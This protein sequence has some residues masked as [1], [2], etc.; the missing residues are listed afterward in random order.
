MSEMGKENIGKIYKNRHKYLEGTKEPIYITSQ[1][2]Y[3][4]YHGYV[5]P[6]QIKE[7]IKYVKTGL[8]LLPKDALDRDWIP[9]F[10]NF[11]EKFAELDCCMRVSY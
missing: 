4:F 2:Q 10:I 8:N 5:T 11:L 9:A 3:A 7:I 6:A 1:E